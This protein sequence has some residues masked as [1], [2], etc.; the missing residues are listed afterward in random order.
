MFKHR[1]SVKLIDF[2]QHQIQC[3]GMDY[4]RILSQETASAFMN[5]YTI[6][7]ANYI[8]ETFQVDTAH[9]LLRVYN[10]ERERYYILLM[11]LSSQ[12]T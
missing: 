1:R 10:R 11:L 6:K 8:Q 9:M 2:I 4:V 12:I 7:V 3:L 5:V